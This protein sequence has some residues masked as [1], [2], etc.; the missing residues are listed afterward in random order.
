MERVLGAPLLNPQILSLAGVL[1]QFNA[2]HSCGLR[3]VVPIRFQE[4]GPGCAAM[5]GPSIG[6]W[7]ECQM[8]FCT[9]ETSGVTVYHATSV[10]SSAC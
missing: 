6:D 1:F 4:R 10:G 5:G 2:R 7:G 8:D 3:Y 9:A